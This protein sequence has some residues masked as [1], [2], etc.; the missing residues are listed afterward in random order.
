MFLI[1]PWR[2]NLRGI[3]MPLEDDSRCN[4]PHGFKQMPTIF[5]LVTTMTTV[6]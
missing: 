3:S 5:K 4:A 6:Y 2:K 1:N